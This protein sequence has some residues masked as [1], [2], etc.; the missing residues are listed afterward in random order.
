MGTAEKMQG[1]A[2]EGCTEL[3]R[4]HGSLTAMQRDGLPPVEQALSC[5]PR[6]RRKGEGEKK[7]KSVGLTVALESHASLVVVVARP[8]T[9]ST[10]HRRRGEGHAALYADVHTEP[11]EVHAADALDR[12]CIGSG[13]WGGAAQGCN[14]Q[15]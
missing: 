13:R 3:Y 12:H 9:R 6:P 4:L 8:V 14:Q 10:R 7:K 2:P 15:R 11:W 5:K 1:H